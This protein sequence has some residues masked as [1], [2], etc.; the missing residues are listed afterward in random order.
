MNGFMSAT[1]V[2]LG[3]TVLGVSTFTG[4]E[5]APARQEA[6]TASD[7]V[8]VMSGVRQ[9]RQAMAMT[10]MI[11]GSVD[12]GIPAVE[13]MVDKGWLKAVPVNPTNVGPSGY[14][15]PRPLGRGRV[16]GMHLVRNGRAVCDEIS[17]QYAGMWPA[18]VSDAP[19][20]GEGCVVTSSGPMAY[21]SV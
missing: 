8:V 20:N 14:A 10:G 2:L 16:V 4:A 21:I 12:Q 19:V 11:D 1:M 5:V 18:P 9:T 15:V 13:R 7:A 17:R 6:E 3:A